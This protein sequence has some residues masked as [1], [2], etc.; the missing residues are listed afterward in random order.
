MLT[1]KERIIE[2]L[3]ARPAGLCDDCL[4]RLADV[5]PRQQV[6]TVCREL[7]EAGKITREK[8]GCPEEEKKIKVINKLVAVG[9]LSQNAGPH[10]T[11]M[12]QE[13]LPPYQANSH[14]VAGKLDNI[15]RQLIA[16]LNHLEKTNWPKSRTVG[17][18]GF[19]ERIGRLTD[20]GAI[21][22][23]ISIMMRMLGSMRNAVVYR[24]CILEKSDEELADSAL[25]IILEWWRKRKVS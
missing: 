20:N 10:N 25:N 15:R 19:S 5:R 9:L 4:S 11:P 8:A 6:N 14:D 12:I 21:P 16:F 7:L 23:R 22:T 18:E 1:S 13:E 2:T 24:D 17:V 3:E